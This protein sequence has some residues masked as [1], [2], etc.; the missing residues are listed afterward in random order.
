MKLIPSQIVRC[1]VRLRHIGGV[2][3]FCGE[4]R[5]ESSRIEPIEVFCSEPREQS[6]FWS[7]PTHEPHEPKPSL[8]PG[9]LASRAA[10]RLCGAVKRR[11]DCYAGQSSSGFALVPCTTV[12]QWLV[13]ALRDSQLQRH[14]PTASAS[15]S[16]LKIC[17]QEGSGGSHAA[18][19]RSVVQSWPYT[20]TMHGFLKER[21]ASASQS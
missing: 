14:A 6:R 18:T 17:R 3:W 8:E 5:A 9:C 2:A 16:N 4:E 20:D 12:L 15:S 19:S 1:D 11:D 13:T 7:E 21:G 10:A